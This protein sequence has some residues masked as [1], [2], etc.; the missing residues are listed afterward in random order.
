MRL[1][2]LANF[3]ADLSKRQA[4]VLE[5]SA[6][7]LTSGEIA[8]IL[9]LSRRTVNYHLSQVKDRQRRGDLRTTR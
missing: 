8:V 7:G 6:R 3:K 9:H 5:L 1:A 4:Q 2:R